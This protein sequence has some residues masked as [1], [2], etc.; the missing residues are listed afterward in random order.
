[1]YNI[2][3][4][5]G[6]GLNSTKSVWDWLSSSAAWKRVYTQRCTAQWLLGRIRGLNWILFS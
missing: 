5:L 6:A 1:L 2:T 3:V 4:L